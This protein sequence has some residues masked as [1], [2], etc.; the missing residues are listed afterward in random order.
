MIHEQICDFLA[1]HFLLTNLLLDTMK[2]TASE[3]HKEGRIV[4]VS[5]EGHRFAYSEGIRFDKINDESR[6]KNGGICIIFPMPRVHLAKIDMIL[7]LCTLLIF[8]IFPIPSYGQ[9]SAYGQSKL[10]NILHANELA[11]RLKVLLYCHFITYWHY[12]FYL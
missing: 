3:S 12:D 9:L 11:R 7:S 6:W 10:S 5:S 4:N 1:G 2:R 8:M